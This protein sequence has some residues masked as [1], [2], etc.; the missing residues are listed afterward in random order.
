A[1]ALPGKAM[2]EGTMWLAR[3]GYRI[4]AASWSPLVSRDPLMRCWRCE[5]AGFHPEWQAIA[6]GGRGAGHEGGQGARKRDGA[7][8]V[9]RGQRLQL[10]NILELDDAAAAVALLAVGLVSEVNVAI[11]AEIAGVLAA[12]AV[13][14]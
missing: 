9:E 12:C 5:F 11:I 14:A 7:V 1:V 2:G 10:L 8:E 3:R 4:S 6:R 13:A